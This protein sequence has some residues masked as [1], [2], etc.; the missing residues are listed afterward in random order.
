VRTF[1]LTSQS[2]FTAQQW[3][4]QKTFMGRVSFSGVWW[5][6]VFGVRSLWHHNLTSYSCLLT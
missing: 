2:T 5:P 1:I 3:R 6:F 4:T